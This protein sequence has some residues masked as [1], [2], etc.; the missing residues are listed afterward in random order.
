MTFKVYWTAAWPEFDHCEK[1]Y[2]QVYPQ[3]QMTEALKHCENL[4]TQRRAGAPISHIIMCNENPDQVGEAGCTP[5]G[6]D[7]N[8]RKRRGFGPNE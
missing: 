3:D 1:A 8:W 6:E 4:R 5:A 2:S 7:Y